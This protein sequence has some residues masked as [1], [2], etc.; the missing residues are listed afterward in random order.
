[1]TFGVSETTEN[2]TAPICFI[3][4]G[5]AGRCHAECLALNVFL[6]SGNGTVRPRPWRLTSPDWP[7]SKCLKSRIQTMSQSRV[8]R[9][10]Q[11][12]AT[13]FNSCDILL[14]PNYGLMPHTRIL[15]DDRLARAIFHPL[16][17]L[18]GGS[19][20]GSVEDSMKRD[21]FSDGCPGRRDQLETKN[22]QKL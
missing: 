17:L 6:T 13:S 3:S 10:N 18:P 4:L 9:S 12:S 5:H 16:D 8:G 11:G 19:R 1:M 7:F 20:V 21:S 22:R 14:L 15:L 2:Q